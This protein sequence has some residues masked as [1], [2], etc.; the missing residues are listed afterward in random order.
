MKV[1]LGFGLGCLMDC[2]GRSAL[3]QTT[4]PSVIEEPLRIE[5]GEVTL[6]ATL[7]LPEGDGPHPAIIFTHGAEPA[8][9][10]MAG[11]RRWANRYV[12][13]GVAA[14]LYDKRGIGDSTGTYI[15]SAD[16]GISAQEVA[17]I[18][19]LLAGDDRID[20]R[21]VGVWG[22]SQGGWIGP[23]A[24]SISPHI[25]FVVMV[26]GPTM[27]PFEQNLY[28][29]G[30]QLRARGYSEQ[31]VLDASGARRINWRY[32]SMQDNPEEARE[33]WAHASAQPWFN[34][35]RNQLLF[36]PD[37]REAYL[38]D[39]RLQ[40]YLVHNAYEPMPVLSTLKIPILAVFG[41]ADTIVPV[42]RSVAGLH[43]AA[44]ISGNDDVTIRVFPHADHGIRILQ[45]DGTRRAPDE[46]FELCVDWVLGQVGRD[47]EQ[48]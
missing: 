47:G 7:F 11:Y 10:N 31:E 48:H 6:G 27:S 23:L 29:K 21:R 12:R 41:D 25:S 26:S 30:H 35:A 36:P 18:A 33:S 3:A 16:L 17:D 24:A 32:Y 4:A 14:L 46:F 19:A 8:S 43:E 44:R 37:Q 42:A 38:R 20:A 1:G 34:D 9:R 15:E 28:D 45:E 2:L 5:S 40:T 39:L 13:R 22:A